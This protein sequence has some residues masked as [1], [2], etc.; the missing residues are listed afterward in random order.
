[1]MM[2][3]MLLPALVSSG[4]IAGCG[5]G[6]TSA[7]GTVPDPIATVQSEAVPVPR[8]LSP[9]NDKGVFTMKVGQTADLVVPDP[10]APDPEVEGRSV[11]VVDVHNVDASGRREWELRAIS[12]GRTTLRA[13]GKH[14]YTIT[15]EVQQ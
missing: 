15:F 10:S 1:M 2:N 3:G 11:Q 5:S 8:S 6:L 13:A 7:T 14:P 4:L 9:A 12:P